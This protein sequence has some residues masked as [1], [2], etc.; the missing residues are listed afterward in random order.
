MES[1]GLMPS[2]PTV[3]TGELRAIPV[4]DIRDVVAGDSD[5]AAAYLAVLDQM[6]CDELGAVDGNREADS[7]RGQDNRRVDADYLAARVDQRSAGVAGIQRGVGLD[8]VV[9]QSARSRSERS[10]KR[11]HHARGNGALEA[12]RISN[13]YGELTHANRPRVT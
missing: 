1:S 11:T 6:P 5:I 7:L 2:T 3:K 13:R 8:N 12:V 10:S 9:D 4:L